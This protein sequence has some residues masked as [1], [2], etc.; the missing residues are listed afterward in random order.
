LGKQI[1]FCGRRK[2]WARWRIMCWFGRGLKTW[3]RSIHWCAQSIMAGWNWW[4]C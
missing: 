4:V 3:R 2:S 1:Y